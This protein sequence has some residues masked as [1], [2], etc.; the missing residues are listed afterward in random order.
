MKKNHNGYLNYELP[1][2]WRV[3][4]DA[5]HLLVYNPD[6]EGTMTLSFYSLVSTEECFEGKLN[7]FAK[8][9]M[10][11]NRIQLKY[12]SLVR[13]KRSGKTIF[14]G[15]GTIPNGQFVKLWV[16]AQYPKIVVARYESDEKNPEVKIC[17]ALVDS[18]LFTF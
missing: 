6:G 1:D 5:D 9:F 18:F 3:E 4:K 14:Y 15:I 13:Y 11:E 2:G 7:I 12:P 16:V 10:E 17:D 8:R